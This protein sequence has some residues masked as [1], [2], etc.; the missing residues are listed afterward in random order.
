MQR[1]AI[2]AAHSEL[3]ERGLLKR[4]EFGSVVTDAL[5]A[6]GIEETAARLAAEI[7]VLAFVTTVAQWAEPAPPGLF[8]EVARTVVNDLMARATTFCAEADRT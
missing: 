7:G 3:Q 8:V 5:V 6:S 4:A 2:V 1:L